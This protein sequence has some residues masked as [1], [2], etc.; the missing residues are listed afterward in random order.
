MGGS[1]SESKMGRKSFAVIGSGISGLSSAWLLSQKHR[2]TLFE[3]ESRV[4]GHSNTV[5]VPIS[6]GHQP[7]DTGFIVYNEVNY[8]NLVALFKHLEVATDP[9]NMSFAV[10]LKNG[11]NEYGSS[12]IN[13]V[14]GQRRNIFSPEFWR[15]ISDIRKFYREAPKILDEPGLFRDVSLGEYLHQNKY[16]TA[17][18]NDFILPMG[19]AIWSTRAD[20]MCE[21]PVET[22]VRFFLSHG[23][24][25]FGTQIPWKTVRGG[26]REYVQ[27]MIA[28]ISHSVM[29]NTAAIKVLKHKRQVQVVDRHGSDHYFDGV[30]IA[31]HAD[32]ALTLLA[33][34]DPLERKILNCFRYTQNRAVLHTDCSLMPRRRRIWSSWNYM[35]TKN[36]NVSITYWMNSLQSIK[37][38]TPLFVSIN[39]KVEPCSNSVIREFNYTHPFYDLRTLNA[40]EH[41]WKL[42]GRHNTWFSGSYFGYGF[43]EDGLQSGL[44]AAEEAGGVR[45]PWRI[46]NESGRIHATRTDKQFIQ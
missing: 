2:V 16:R 1:F 12:D 5:D 29:I 13:S 23:L 22:F 20:E 19:G 36:N 40:Q 43:H 31:T 42:Q 27:R 34:P 8:P 14:F 33:D 30:I 3:K 4:G 44:A 39:P 11:Q 9:S 26:S 41:L 6:N 28:G 46:P 17:F 38:K 21:H 10:S 18:V 37:Q 45:R 35:G 24:L 15:M 32:Q 7:V 25:Q